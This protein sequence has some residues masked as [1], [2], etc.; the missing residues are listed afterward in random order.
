MINVLVVDDDKL[1]RKGL[2]TF[3]PWAKFGMHVS[4][5]AGNGEKAM[6][7]LESQPVDLLITDL[8]MPVMSGIELL[9]IVRKK[10]PR[11]HVVVLTLHRDFEYIQEALRLGAID[12]IAK[13]QMEED[14]FEEIL[15]RI[16]E[17][18]A[19]SNPPLPAALQND[20][21][22]PFV[23]QSYALLHLEREIDH[24]WLNLA[25]ADVTLLEADARSWICVPM[26]GRED[27]G[28]KV[29]S[30]IARLEP[31]VVLLILSDFQGMTVNDMK[32][33]IRDYSQKA[34]FYAY[35]PD[36]TIITVSRADL[37]MEISE[38]DHLAMEKIKDR[39]LIST[40]IH[41]EEEFQS[42]LIETKSLRLQLNQLI[43]MLYSLVTEWKRMFVHTLSGNIPAIPAVHSWFAVEQWLG[44]VRGC[45]RQSM[46]HLSYSPEIV[47]LI[48]KAIMIIHEEMDRQV[49]AAELAQR[50]ILSRSYFSQCFKDI[51]GKTFNEYSRSVR[52]EKAK[53]YLLNTNKPIVWIAEQT[54]YTDEKYFSRIFRELVDELPSEY[55]Q[56]HRR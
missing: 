42:L 18:I 6:E 2:I 51:I 20:S 10:Y 55:R 35:H 34:L 3:L 21:I 52:I 28:F 56:N 38:T 9:R 12:Y 54:G 48:T 32:R 13:V 17:R 46:K 44:E 19:E 41:N 31:N 5:E 24:G 4:G 40:W 37:Q 47:E 39:W 22:V 8:S 14:Q 45:I 27:E 15:G 25:H 26:A 23:K 53:E 11:I 36:Q 7:F 30:D 50:L 43:G 33:W 1:V 16:A 29:L 49:T